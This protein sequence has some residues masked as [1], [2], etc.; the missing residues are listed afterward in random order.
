[1]RSAS[2]SASSRSWV[3]SRQVAP[4][5]SHRSA[6]QR[7]R[8]VRVRASS[9]PNGSSSSSRSWA[10]NTVRAKATRW[11]IPPLSVAGHARS[12][13][14]QPELGEEGAGACRGLGAWYRPAPPAR[15]RR[16][17]GRC[18][19]AAADRAAAYSPPAPAAAP[20]D[21]HA[22]RLSRWLA[23][24]V[25][26]R[27]RA[28]SSCHSRSAPPAPRT[29]PHPHAARRLA[30]PSVRPSLRVALRDGAAP[31]TNGSRFPSPAHLLNR[32]SYEKGTP[33]ECQ[34]PRSAVK[35]VLLLP[36]LALPRSGSV[37]RWRI[38]PPSQPGFPQAPVAVGQSIKLC[39]NTCNTGRS[40]LSNPHPSPV[41]S[42]SDTP[43]GLKPD[44]F[45]GYAQPN[46]SR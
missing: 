13:P 37:G 19:R 44:G 33:A 42:I 38:E 6:S 20:G 34:R 32:D 10:A 2:S 11:R 24:L 36:A 46:G 41:L 26:R 35:L 3:T 1:M 9:A 18:A 43:R 27:S 16:C 17:P 31:S 21:R 7:C 23:S 5:R 39:S 45:S 14:A 12:N 8:L 29:R 28:A 4:S 30:A 25:P 22:G 40:T 15:R